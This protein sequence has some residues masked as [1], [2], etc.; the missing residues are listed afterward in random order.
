M[1]R[2]TPSDGASGKGK[3]QSPAPATPNTNQTAAPA[4]APAPQQAAQQPAPAP[5]ST[6]TS[7]AQQ[8]QT[9]T[10]Q[11]AQSKLTPIR[12]E[13]GNAT[14][15]KT[16]TSS[17]GTTM[18]AQVSKPSLARAANTSPISRNQSSAAMDNIRK[19]IEELG[20]AAEFDNTT[21]TM[22]ELDRNGANRNMAVLI[23]CAT[24][25]NKPGTPVAYHTLLLE[26][27]G[28]PRTVRRR[29]NNGIN[30]GLNNGGVYEDILY[31]SDGYDE[32][33]REAVLLAV[34]KKFGNG[35]VNVDN[36]KKIVTAGNIVLLDAMS[37]TVPATL[38][39][40]KVANVRGAVSNGS[41][42]ATTVLRT[43]LG[44][45]DDFKLEGDVSGQRWTTSM[46]VSDAAFTD[47]MGI[48]MRGDVAL[49]LREGGSDNVNNNN[50][51]YNDPA[52]EVLTHQVLG[53]Q[54]LA[55]QPTPAAQMA[56]MNG[57]LMTGASM[58]L[59]L[60]L[61][62]GMGGGMDPSVYMMFRSRFI[63]TNLDPIFNPTL[64]D[65]LMGL[66]TTQLLVEDRR[67][68]NLWVKRH[69]L[70]AQNPIN[71]KNLHDLGALGL[72]VMRPGIGEQ[73]GQMVKSRF[74][75][76]GAKGEEPVLF[77][78]LNSV[79]YPDAV[80]SMDVSET[81]TFSWILGVFASAALGDISANDEI[82]GASDYVTRG[83][84]SNIYQQLC[85]GAKPPVMLNDGVLIN[86][87]RYTDANGQ[88][89]DIR[90]VDQLVIEN[91]FGETAPEM[92]DRWIRMNYDTSIDEEFRLVEQRAIISMLFSNAQFTG[93][94][95]RVTFRPEFLLALNKAIAACGG[96]FIARWGNEAPQST[97]RATASF[98]NGV[99]FQGGLS[100]AYVQ[101]YR[102]QQT[103]LGLNNSGFG[104]WGRF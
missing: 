82:V 48:P 103:G 39:L 58:G 33:M 60:G 93:R 64:P 35:P 41:V 63:I 21:L 5:A 62:M 25:R 55:W 50:L 17:T 65:T 10:P 75:T 91:A 42:A 3:P 74:P 86:M 89:R 49:E 1:H 77:S 22:L 54:D 44:Q 29:L 32:H 101:N 57:N 26:E 8:A 2:L 38:D 59:G 66:A 45:T 18:N 4:Q 56:A 95:R 81:G 104:R 15:N 99:N 23:V 76:T 90:E 71:G 20:A 37:S 19:A 85:G 100:G 94:A 78:I 12:V 40:S 83:H 51:S 84:F 14:L 28:Q 97:L 73:A 92:V 6:A 79:V 88:L 98:L 68:Q 16:S 46:L 43:F 52:G 30:S 34:A 47:L 61:G 96:R 69:T 27:T 36:Q 102:P 80:V 70:G 53:F 11:A 31:P 72:E 13:T 24:E 67:F 7:S 9:I 87:G